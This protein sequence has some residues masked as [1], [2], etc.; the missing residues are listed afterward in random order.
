MSPFTFYLSFYIT[1]CFPL[2]F[3]DLAWEWGFCELVSTQNLFRLGFSFDYSFVMRSDKTFFL[4]CLF[5]QVYHLNL[6]NVCSWFNTF[7]YPLTN[8]WFEHYS[9]IKLS[10][11]TKEDYYTIRN[12]GY[13]DSFIKIKTAILAI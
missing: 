11:K 6:W 1:P 2:N 10:Q 4:W 3:Q 7:F 9:L 5:F 8:D 12:K 13:L